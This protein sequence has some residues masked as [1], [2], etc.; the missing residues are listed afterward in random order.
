MPGQIGKNELNKSASRAYSGAEVAMS[1]PNNRALTSDWRRAL[2]LLAAN[3]L[4]K[5]LIAEIVQ[6]LSQQ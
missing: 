4:V 3:A 2:L 6:T 1:S 5:K